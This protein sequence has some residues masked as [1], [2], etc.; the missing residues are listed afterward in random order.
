[1]LREIPEAIEVERQWAKD[2]MDH[3]G[4]SEGNAIPCPA[5]KWDD[6][7]RLHSAARD[8]DRVFAND[9]TEIQPEDIPMIEA[10]IRAIENWEPE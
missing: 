8:V 1:M 3:G 10:I 6:R 2:M 4:D 7:M 5:C 9:A